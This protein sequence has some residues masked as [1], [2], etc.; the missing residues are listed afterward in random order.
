MGLPVLGCGAPRFP[1]PVL[2]Y[3]Y[4][5]GRPSGALVGFMASEVVEAAGA[6]VEGGVDWG[7]LMVLVRVGTEVCEE[8][9]LLTRSAGPAVP[10]VVGGAAE[11]AEEVV[12]RLVCELLAAACEEDL[13]VEPTNLRKRLFIRERAGATA[14]T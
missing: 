3:W 5:G 2:A 4:D 14:A 1:V 6:V 10:L 7:A 13:L 8:L 9:V 12:E 11:A